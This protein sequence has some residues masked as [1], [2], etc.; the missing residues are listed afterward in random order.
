M[1]IKGCFLF[2][3]K[4]NA[5]VPPCLIGQRIVPNYDKYNVPMVP[6]VTPTILLNNF[7][8][9]KAYHKGKYRKDHFLTPLI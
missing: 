5:W 8:C 7:T 4:D 9:V 6:N 3:T 1:K 2:K